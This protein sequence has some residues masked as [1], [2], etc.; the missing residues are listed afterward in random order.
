[1]LTQKKMNCGYEVI[2]LRGMCYCEQGTRNIPEEDFDKG[3]CTN[4]ECIYNPD[5]ELQKE[6]FY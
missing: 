6:F 1:M 4:Y 3:I 2:E 5:N